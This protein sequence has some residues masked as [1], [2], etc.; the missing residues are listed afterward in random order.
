[1]RAKQVC[2]SPGCPTLV[3]RGTG[4]CPMCRQQA[5]Q[6]R[7]KTTTRGYGTEH[8]QARV[9]ALN[10]YSPTDPCPRCGDPLGADRKA[11]DLDHTDDRAGYLG[12]SHSACNRATKGRTA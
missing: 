12:L 6:A 4:K 10:S 3:E 7:G 5:E 9:V 8:Q 2:P 1:M 11:L